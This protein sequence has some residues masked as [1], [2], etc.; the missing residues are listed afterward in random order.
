VLFIPFFNFSDQSRIVKF[1]AFGDERT[2]SVATE[3]ETITLNCSVE[4]NPKSTIAIAFRNK[5]LRRNVSLKSLVHLHKIKSCFDDGVY[6]CSAS[7][8]YNTKPCLKELTLRVRCKLKYL[9]NINLIVR[10]L[11]D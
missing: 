8:V 3:N 6:S 4:S 5:E 10:F 9:F 2:N 1:I 11:S 7:N